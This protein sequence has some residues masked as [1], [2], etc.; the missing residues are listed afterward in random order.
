[1][2][3]RGL[4][5]DT[6]DRLAHLVRDAGKSLSRT[7]QVRL[8]QRSI[9]Y[10]HWTFLRILWKR[11][12]ISQSELSELAGV[13]APSTVAAVRS[14]EKCGYVVRRRK[15]GNRKRIY[16]HLTAN[17]RNLERKLTPLAIEVNDIAT[18]GLSRKQIAE[19]RN[20]LIKII[21]NLN[22]TTAVT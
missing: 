19:F 4:E 2:R 11:D 6:T 21:A 14:M 8:A 13:M 16:I 10:G 7:L 18:V 9:A 3:K 17:G 5:I 12:G 15:H 20:A 1:M 22:A